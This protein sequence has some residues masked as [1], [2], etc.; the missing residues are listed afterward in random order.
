MIGVDQD[1]NWEPVGNLEGARLAVQLY[2][3]DLRQQKL[4]EKEPASGIQLS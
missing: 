1:T 3:E 4:R 2:E